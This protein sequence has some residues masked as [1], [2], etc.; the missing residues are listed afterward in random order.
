MLSLCWA[1]DFWNVGNAYGY[2]VH[3]RNMQEQ[4][5]KHLKLDW[6]API[7]LAIASADRFERIPGKY[8]ILFSMF[9]CPDLPNTY[10]KGIDK[11]DHLI[12]PCNWLKPIF[13]KYTDKPIDVCLEGCDVDVFDYKERSL[14][15]PGKPFRILWVGAPNI[16]KGFAHMA[17]VARTLSQDPRFE[18]Y[19][20]T[21][22][23][24]V[25]PMEEVRKQW[26]EN[27][28]W[29]L[30]KYGFDRVKE[31]IEKMRE[32]NV[33]GGYDNQIVRKGP[34]QNIITDTRDVSL[35]ELVALYHSAHLFVLPS[36][37]EGFGLTLCEAMATGC[38]SVST[39]V[40]GQ[41]DFFD[42]DVGYTIGYQWR[43]QTLEPYDL[44]SRVVWPDIDDVF[45]AI[46]Q[47]YLNYEEA[48]RRA[49]AARLRIESGFTWNISGERLFEI[50]RGAYERLREAA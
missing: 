50:V 11:A 33:K 19:L 45:G 10:I 37:G 12:V 36:L 27:R 39:S 46:K 43:R 18:V 41:K 47:V 26:D 15:L 4:I 49:R 32:L 22:V 8:N 24:K 2:S 6:D 23:P 28:G 44:K 17:E 35:R 31:A 14:P 5:Q 25:V 21:T 29:M 1:T 42:N 48:K 13:R 3:N 30:K 16:R 9:E 7:S 40:T 20:K 38:P 34:H